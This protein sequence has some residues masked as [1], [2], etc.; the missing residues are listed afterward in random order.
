MSTNLYQANAQWATRPD[1][2]RFEDLPTMIERCRHYAESAAQ[3]TTPLRALSVI[4][5]TG[6]NLA[7]VGPTGQAATLT[8]WS[9]SQLANRV[10]TPA[11]YLKT[12]PPAMSA[13]LVNHGLQNRTAEGDE[14]KLLIHRNGSLVCRAAT[15]GTYARIWN[16]ELL[17]RVAP[18]KLEHARQPKPMFCGCRNVHRA[19]WPSRWAT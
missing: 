10:Q 5:T 7:I 8:N 6:N 1:D 14:A 9:F 17:E 3:A 15:S 13:M 2:E 19:G 12:L 4:E 16:Y 11:G 18:V